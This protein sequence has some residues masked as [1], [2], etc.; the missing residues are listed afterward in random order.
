MV[1][2][3][4]PMHS[5]KS[6]FASIESAIASGEWAEPEEQAPAPA[7]SPAAAP[8]EPPAEEPAAPEAPSEPASDENAV[9]EGAD[10]PIDPPA[11]WKKDRVEAFKQLPRAMQETIAE[12][13]REREIATNTA[14]R[15][16]A[17]S[18]KA[19][20]AAEKSALE[21]IQQY[22]HQLKTIIPVLQQQIAGEF[23]D[24]K[25]LADAQ[26]LA[27]TD[28]ARYIQ[29]DAAQRALSGAMADQQRLQQESR[30]RAIKAHNETVESEAQKLREKLPELADEEAYSKFAS[31]LGKYLKAE[32]FS[33]DEIAQLTDHR[34]ALVARKA[35]LYDRAEAAKKAAV[36]K[37]VPKVQVPGVGSSKA[38]T[39]AEDRAARM[40]KLEQRDASLEEWAE[41][42]RD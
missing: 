12:R 7:E 19:A 37:Q 34:T 5:G 29:W 20:E 10:P 14:K 38:S 2:T 23:S 26:A 24:I 27:K 25:T 31:D 18:R 28:P 40:K 22:D 33:Q 41:L 13:E 1:D 6:A 16:A 15:E 35:M 42:L 3:A 9:E 32:G 4:A 8:P 21:R 30:E 36:V 11:S 39:A 17:E